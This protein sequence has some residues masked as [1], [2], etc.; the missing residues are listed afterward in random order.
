VVA[1]VAAILAWGGILVFDA[2]RGPVGTVAATLGGV[3]QVYPLAVYVLT[4]A[5][6]GLMAV[7]A[8]VISRS[9]VR[10]LAAR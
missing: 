5:F 6:S 8:A 2:V 1:G 4:L 3:L 7:C 9:L 10:A